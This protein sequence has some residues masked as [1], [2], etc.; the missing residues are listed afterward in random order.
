M[1]PWSFK[2]C[3]GYAIEK[4]LKINHFKV[5][6]PPTLINLPIDTAI[7]KLMKDFKGNHGRLFERVINYFCMKGQNENIY[8]KN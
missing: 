1:V 8:G 2:E 7:I 6:L 5:A 4:C 3:Y